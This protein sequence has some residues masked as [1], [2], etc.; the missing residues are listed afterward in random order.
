MTIWSII[1]A[2]GWVCMLLS[3][4]LNRWFVGISAIPEASA[5]SAALW[6]VAS[7]IAAPITAV[8]VWF[9]PPKAAKIVI[10][11]GGTIPAIAAQALIFF[12]IA[13]H[14]Q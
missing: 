4:I 10:L 12:I 2:W 13:K 7:M 3:V 9:V 11:I 1:I 5:K 8:C 6:L 14:A